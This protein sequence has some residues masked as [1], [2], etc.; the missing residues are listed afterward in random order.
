M[1]LIMKN[2]LLGVSAVVLSMIWVI[3]SHA[4]AQF[5]FYPSAKGSAEYNDNIF[6]DDED[7]TSDMIYT[8]G[9]GL[10]QEVLWQ[11]AG[12]ILNYEPSYSWYR[13]EGDLDEWRHLVEAQIYKDY[14]KRTRLNLRNTYLRTTRPAD[15]SDERDPDNPREGRQIEADTNRR[16]RETF[17]TNVA[18]AKL[19][20]QFGERDSIYGGFEYRRLRQ[21]EST[22]Q[23]GDD[24]NSNENDIYSPSAGLE[25]WFT[26][27]WGF[28]LDGKYSR[29]DLK[30]NNDRNIVDGTFR[31]LRKF[32]RHLDGFIEY[33]HSYVTYDDEDQNADYQVY[34]PSLGIRWQLERNAYVRLG[35]GY[36]FQDVDD[37]DNPDVDSS[38]ESGFLLDS[39]VF[40]RWD[41]RRANIDLRTLSGYRQDDTGAEDNG[42]NI[43]YDARLSGTYAFFRRLRGEAFVN[44]RW[45]DFPD[46]ENARTDKTLT[47]GAGL[48]WSPLKW[49]F[50]NLNYELRDRES[51]N[52]EDEYTENRVILRLT[53]TPELPFRFGD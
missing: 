36:Y 24:N 40:R 13:D 41:W 3:S 49:M 34:R 31:F 17:Y 38:N 52:S 23:D 44:Y 47:T 29:R 32:T 20:H 8:T 15:R 2:Y 5:N 16:G 45:S 18:T 4:A 14:S 7:E 53:I 26:P 10:R 43:F 33:D 25:Y 9:I 37:S 11:T 6:L 12:A 42:F 22:T 21:V 46:Q 50:W 39:E 27:Q 48:R 35:A 1:G 28:S 51:N 30:D 19:D